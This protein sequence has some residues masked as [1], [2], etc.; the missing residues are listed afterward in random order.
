MLSAEWLRLHEAGRLMLTERLNA[1]SAA[2]HAGYESP[3]RFSREFKLYF[4][5]SPAEMMKEMR[6]A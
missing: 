6:T 1:A 2:F 3:S 4:G 5:Q